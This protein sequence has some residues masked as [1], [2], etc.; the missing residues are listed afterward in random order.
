M[1]HST[2]IDIAKKLRISPS[3]VSRA[4]NDHPDIKK[5]TK[6]LVRKVAQE[7]HYT[8]NPIA[9][10]LQSNRTTTIGVI[11]PEIKHDFFASA[12]SGIEEVAYQSG[13]TIILCQSNESVDR[14][15]V[16][17]NVLMQHR[18]AGIIASISQNTLKWNHFQDVIKRKIPLVF[19]DRVI[20]DAAVSSVVIDDYRSAFDA[21]SYLIGKG[22]KKIAHFSGPSKLGICIKRRDGYIDAM[23]Q[24]HYPIP[25][26]FIC[27]GGLHEQDGYS[28]MDALI[29]QKTLP[30]AIFAIN[31]PVA[32][33][34]FQRIR[35]A[36]YRIP[37]DIAIMGFSNNK[38]T[39]LMEPPLTTVDQPSFEMGRSAARILVQTIEEGLTEP[40]H[41]VLNTKLIIRGS[42]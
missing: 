12:I 40:C 36:G 26:N 20:E 24:H 17:T 28:A 35:E 11:V 30:D 13:Y 34:A 19:F 18:V 1:K 29:Q 8:P 25:D 3:T 16:N 15:V 27:Y 21:V 14:E 33:G 41:L 9:I 31:D 4:L 2:I 42:T 32:I 38:I 5:E 23:K 7:L 10:S 22:Y 6:E 39:N 37:K